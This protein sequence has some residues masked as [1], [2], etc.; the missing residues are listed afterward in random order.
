LLRQLTELCKNFAD[1]AKLTSPRRR[2]SAKTKRGRTV[3][4]QVHAQAH[5]GKKS[6]LARQIVCCR[7]SRRGLAG[8]A[9]DGLPKHAGDLASIGVILCNGR[10]AVV[11]VLRHTSKPIGVA[12][13]QLTSAIG[14]FEE[15][16]L[17][18][19]AEDFAVSVVSVRVLA[20]SWLHNFGQDDKWNFCL[21]TG[22]LVP[23]NQER[24]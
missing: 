8:R 5:H 13:Y 11:V 20:Q 4:P 6:E 17:M 9:G 19:E 23:A 16:K 3:W 22:T 1:L 18:P 7:S 10:V 21:T 14:M 15:L 24:P 12:A 2:A